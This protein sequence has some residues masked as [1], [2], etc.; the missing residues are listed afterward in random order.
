[1]SDLHLYSVNWQDGMLVTQQHLKDQE[2]YF[3]ELARWYALDVGD[4]YGL[5]RKVFSGK[6]ALSLNLSVSANRLRVEVIRCQ[7]VTPDGSIIEINET[8][9]SSVQTEKEVDAPVVPVYI[10]VNADSRKQVGEADPKED[11]PRI[12]YL[13]GNYC[14]ELGR[15]PN[16]PEARYLQIAAV[17]INGNEVVH[18]DGYYPPCLSLNAD[19]RLTRKAV[20]YR[21]RLENLLSLSSR[22]YAAIAEGGALAGEQTSLQTAF[23]EIIYQF[24][25]HL[26]STL[27]DFVVGRNAFHPL[28]LVMFFKKLFR[29]FSTLLN[30]KPGLKDFL[31]ERF[32][33]KQMNSEVGRFMSSIDGFLLA[34]YNH[35]DLGGHLHAIDDIMANLREIMGFLAQVKRE[36]LGEQA[37][38]TDTLTYHGRTYRVVEYGGS[39]LEQ[40]GE[41]SYLLIDVPE[42]CPISDTVILITKDLFST[43]EWSSMQVRLGLNEARGLGETDP[44]EVDVVTFGDKVALRAQDMLRSP[45]VRQVTL[46]FRGAGEADQF[47]NLGKM[48][49][50]VYAV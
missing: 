28:Y 6:P 27:D 40:V 3:E 48:D 21:N 10:G 26:S 13:V 16:L 2:K 1:M 14:L 42:P 38:A 7:A 25:Y 49:L 34:E 43:A 29:V 30:L 45:S 17:S 44:V 37:V 4:K 5:V 18:S 39:R 32:F 35:A 36:Q 20:D 22:A 50:I 8:N 24:A 15:P 46:I 9:Q 41:L 23:R 19:E 47:A 12:P 33:V 31:N 11:L